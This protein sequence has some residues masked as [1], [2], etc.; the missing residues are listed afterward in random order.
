MQLQACIVIEQQFFLL[1]IRFRQASNYSLGTNSC[2][3]EAQQYMPQHTA[4]LEL[5]NSQKHSLQ[6]LLIRHV[7]GQLMGLGSHQ[8]PTHHRSFQAFLPSMYRL[9]IRLQER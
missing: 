9:R 6:Q 5:V 8:A 7:R 3:F 4:Q 2:L 1:E